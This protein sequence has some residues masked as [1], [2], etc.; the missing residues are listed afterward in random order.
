MT[1]FNAI[2]PVGTIQ[3]SGT[4]AGTLPGTHS[5]SPAGVGNLIALGTAVLGSTGVSSITGGNCMGWSRAAGPI[6]LAGIGG[7]VDFWTATVIATGSAS[8]TVTPATSGAAGSFSY[9]EFYGGGG[10]TIW[11]VDGTQSGTHGSSS[12]STSMTF[13]TLVPGGSSRLYFGWGI[14]GTPSA[15]T[16]GYTRQ[17]GLFSTYVMIYDTS[18]STSQTP[19][20]TTASSEYETCA[21]LVTASPGLSTAQFLPFFI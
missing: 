2:S 12:N 9:Q 17:S 19:V 16:S 15:V 13:P 4:S 6:Y 1:I 8:I 11:A 18:V 21:A 5:I 14:G 3:N 10:G 7:T 20:A